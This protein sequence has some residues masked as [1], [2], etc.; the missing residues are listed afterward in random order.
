M[1]SGKY[2]ELNEWIEQSDK[3]KIS[4]INSFVK[5]FNN[6]IDAVVNAIRLQYNN[7]L[8]EGSVNKIKLV[9]RNNVRDV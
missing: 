1:F 7:G 6:D 2:L 8:A 5:G 3:L 4:Q 9:K